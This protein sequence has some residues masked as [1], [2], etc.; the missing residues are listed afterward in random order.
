M[1]GTYLN[2]HSLAIKIMSQDEDTIKYYG[3]GNA[4]E[5]YCFLTINLEDSSFLESNEAYI[6]RKSVV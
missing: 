2:N 5:L 1:R 3:S 4:W 6:D